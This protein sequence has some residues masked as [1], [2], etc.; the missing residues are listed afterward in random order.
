M[1]LFPL[2]WDRTC[3]LPT[4]GTNVYSLCTVIQVYELPVNHYYPIMTD[5]VAMYFVYKFEAGSWQWYHIITAWCLPQL[6]CPWIYI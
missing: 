6:T 2:H 4:V 3:T 1:R 5:M